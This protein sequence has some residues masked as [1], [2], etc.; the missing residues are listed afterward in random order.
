MS[1]PIKDISAGDTVSSMVDKINYNFDLLS[2]KGG[3]PAGIQGIQGIRGPIGTQGEQ[4]IGGERGSR[5]YNFNPDPDEHPAANYN[6]GD[7]TLYGG[8]FYIV[9]NDGSENYWE[10]AM[11]INEYAESP[12]TNTEYR[13]IVPRVNYSDNQIVFGLGNTD[14]ENADL[15]TRRL[16]SIS[17][18]ALVISGKNFEENY[19]KYHISLYGKK[20]MPTSYSNDYADG[21]LYIDYE[22]PLPDTPILKLEGRDDGVVRMCCGNEYVQVGGGA[23]TLSTRNSMPVATGGTA[24]VTTDEAGNVTNEYKWRIGTANHELYPTETLD[25]GSPNCRIGDI[26]VKQGAVVN[27]IDSNYG[28]NDFLRFN[29]QTSQT[30]FP[31]FALSSRGVSFGIQSAN[32]AEHFINSNQTHFG[33]YVGNENTKNAPHITLV[34]KSTIQSQTVSEHIVIDDSATP[35]TLTPNASAYARLVAISIDKYIDIKAKNNSTVH[36]KAIGNTLCISGADYSSKTYGSGKDIVITGG[37]ANNSVDTMESVGG[38]VFIT[39]GASVED[40]H[41]MD[42][43]TNAHTYI[44]DI[45]RMGNVIIGINPIYHTDIQRTDVYS[46]DKEYDNLTST[47]PSGVEFFDTNNVAIHAN[48]IVIDSNANYRKGTYGRFANG[49]YSNT[50]P[51]TLTPRNSTLQLSG[52]NV[53]KHTSPIVL[54]ASQCCEHQL[55]SGTMTEVFQIKYE[56]GTFSTTKKNFQLLDSMRDTEKEDSLFFVVNQVWQKA[57]NVV[58]VNL[59]AEWYAYNNNDKQLY[60]ISDY[61]FGYNKWSVNSQTPDYTGYLPNPLQ[62]PMLTTWYQITQSGGNYNFTP[63]NKT[64]AKMMCNSNRPDEVYQCGSADIPSI[65]K[66]IYKKIYVNWTDGENNMENQPIT[67][68]TIPISIN[69]SRVSSIYGNGNVGTEGV[70]GYYKIGG[71]GEYTKID[72][73]GTT[74]KSGNITVGDILTDGKTS[75]VYGNFGTNENSSNSTGTR[76]ALHERFGKRYGPVITDKNSKCHSNI[77]TDPRMSMPSSNFAWNE[78]KFIKTTPLNTKYTYFYPQIL[79]D[80]GNTEYYKNTSYNGF[81]NTNII[82]PNRCFR[83]VIGLYTSMSLNYSYVITPNLDDEFYGM[84]YRSIIDDDATTE[85]VYDSQN[86]EYLDVAPEPIG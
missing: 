42:F 40:A 39:G 67:I 73:S 24:I 1:I 30:N 43:V 8:V 13:T 58:N 61:M 27:F 7:M 29:V 48:R 49:N 76:G 52:I 66:I 80:F 20:A 12:F 16:D 19:I 22:Q 28:T 69:S 38:T 17:G 18:S 26:Y 55:L 5:I 6:T 34:T 72:D 14:T 59:R 70:S 54:D 33:I 64:L 15:Q 63:Y 82:T 62:D 51:Y 25:I 36:T 75:I 44:A 74:C 3:G 50:F 81:L 83:P 32:A 71:G 79:T 47:N 31:V 37:R 78:D 23:I 57:G 85:D 86:N 11:D 35:Y 60:Y 4:G 77:A 56:N 68:F 46:A 9:L 53:I 21:N 45:R 41:I 65:Y 84:Q 10:P 2:L